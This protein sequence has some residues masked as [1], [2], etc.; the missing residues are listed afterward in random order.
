M[1]RDSE[2]AGIGSRVRAARERLA[3]TR[4]VLAFRSGLSWSAIAQVESGRRTNVRPTTLAALAR[5]LGV[6]IDYLVEGSP[7]R[8]PM[9]EHSVFAYHSEEQVTTTVGPFLAE[10]IERSEALIVA[11]TAPIIEL[12]REHLGKDAKKIKFFDASGFYSTPAA[13]LEAYERFS[14]ARLARGANWVRALGEPILTDRSHRDVRLW[15]RYESLFN[16]MF[17]A[18]PMSSVCLY[19]ARSLAPE[20]IRQAHLTHPH[21]IGDDGVSKSPDYAEPG[22]FVFEP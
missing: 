2:I 4:E 21:T 13:A 12:L 15:I 20:I 22:R 5:T 6:S 19:D 11:V 9:L 1:T 14:A 3:W 7:P 17:G 10:G 16:V 8:K 18:H